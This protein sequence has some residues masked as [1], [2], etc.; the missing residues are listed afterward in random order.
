MGLGSD[1]DIDEK[2]GI[3]EMSNVL[4]YNKQATQW[5]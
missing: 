3:L 4:L 5:S 2:A 1:T